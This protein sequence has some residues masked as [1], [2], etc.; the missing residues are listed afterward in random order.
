MQKLPPDGVAVAIVANT[1]IL[2]H[3]LGFGQNKAD[4]KVCQLEYRVQRATSFL[5]QK[6]KVIQKLVEN[7]ENIFG[8]HL[9]CFWELVSGRLCFVM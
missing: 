7:I 9:Q 4:P 1:E 3:N 8:P 6:K 5:E 2:E